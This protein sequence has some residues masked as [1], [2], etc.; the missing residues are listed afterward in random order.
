MKFIKFSLVGGMCASLGEVLLYLLTDFAGVYYLL[1]AV[2]AGEGVVIFDFVL[3]KRWVFEAWKRGSVLRQY[4][5]FRSSLIPLALIFLALFWFL[6]DVLSI[7]YLISYPI[8]LAII[9]VSAFYVNL[10]WVWK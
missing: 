7:R 4:V 5:K 2:L 8:S 9:G 3:N 6:T 1:S 10:K